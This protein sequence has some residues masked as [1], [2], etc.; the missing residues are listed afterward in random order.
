MPDFKFRAV[1]VEL[2][3]DTGGLE[4]FF[5]WFYQLYY[6]ELWIPTPFD[7]LD[8]IVWVLDA[9]SSNSWSMRD[10]DNPPVRVFA[11]NPKNFPGG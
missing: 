4:I 6:F 2:T 1:D 11:I 8:H 10:Y 3:E 7:L 5:D 9:Y